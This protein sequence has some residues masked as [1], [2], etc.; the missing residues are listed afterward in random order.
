[1]IY[2]YQTQSGLVQSNKPCAAASL[3]NERNVY[4]YLRFEDNTE[5]KLL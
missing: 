3:D 2:I 4:Y 1:M 5:V